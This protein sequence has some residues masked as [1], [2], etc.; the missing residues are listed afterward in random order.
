MNLYYI[1]VNKRIFYIQEIVSTDAEDITTQK[2]C[3][4]SEY[5]NCATESTI[6]SKH[7]SWFDVYE[8]PV[9]ISCGRLCLGK[10]L[11]WTISNHDYIM[12]G[13]VRVLL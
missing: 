2:L 10:C 13:I 3:I 12:C 6:R 5:D 4:A 1:L 7:C 9:N 8:V 11:P